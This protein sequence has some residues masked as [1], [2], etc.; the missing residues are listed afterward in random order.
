VWGGHLLHDRLGKPAS[1]QPIG[2]SWEV[3]EGDVVWGDESVTLAELCSQC[4][5]SL[6]GPYV[7]S[8][9]P[10]RFPLLTKF[11]DAHQPLSVQVHP[12]DQQAQ[13]LENL[14]NGKTEAWIIL[15]AEP[16]AW[17]IHGLVHAISGDELRD[18]LVNGTADRLLRR[19]PVAAGDVIYVSAGTIHAI[20]PG[21]LL[22][23]VQQSSDTTYRLY[24]WNR[25]AEGGVKRELH[26]DKGLEVSS[27][28]VSP[29]PIV[30][31]LGWSEGFN[32]VE[33]ILA[34]RYFGVRRL[35]LDQEFSLKPEASFAIVTTLDGAIELLRDGQSVS[36]TRGSSIVIPAGPHPTSIRPQPTAEVLIES[37][38]PLT[39]I[40]EDLAGHGL[41]GPD[42]DSFMA[43]FPL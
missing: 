5:A 6:L 8:Q 16:E 7:Q 19:Q 18:A 35:R 24:D 13:R 14:P 36:L 40:R 22:H 3:W 10:N 27:L 30:T 29:A 17:I 33:Y 25:Q 32:E 4:G 26:L 38:M 20:G 9:T 1:D 43:Q 34:S 41:Q 31:A 39:S 2:E 42:I 37:V 12:N 11:I 15:A 28:D 23:E 21:V